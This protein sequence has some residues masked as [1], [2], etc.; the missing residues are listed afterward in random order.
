M[1]SLL[2]YIV[3]LMLVNSISYLPFW[4]TRVSGFACG[5][6][7]QLPVKRRGQSHGP[8]YFWTPA[9]FPKLC[10]LEKNDATFNLVT[11]YSQ[12]YMIHAPLVCHPNTGLESIRS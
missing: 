1:F 3:A 8:L 6:Q 4:S 5:E 12:K 2:V 7:E 9:L 11:I 10:L